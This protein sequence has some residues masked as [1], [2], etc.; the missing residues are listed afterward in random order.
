MAPTKI[1][2]DFRGRACASFCHLRRRL[3]VSL[4][5]H[6]LM[7]LIRNFISRKKPC[8]SEVV[9]IYQIT[10]YRNFPTFAILCTCTCVGPVCTCGSLCAARENSFSRQAPASE[11]SSFHRPNET[12]FTTQ[13]EDWSLPV[14]GRLFLFEQTFTRAD[15]KV[16]FRRGWN[17]EDWFYF[18]SCDDFL[19]RVILTGS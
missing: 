8:L 2:S 19:E 4:P 1:P 16:C 18:L 6:S 12:R 3:P 7:R 14:V 17:K 10:L 9:H 5:F 15:G 11:L 13:C